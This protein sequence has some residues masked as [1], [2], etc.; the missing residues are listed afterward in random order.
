MLSQTASFGQQYMVKL[1]PLSS[2]ASESREH[3]RYCN[4]RRLWKTKDLSSRTNFAICRLVAM[5]WKPRYGVFMD[6]SYKLTYPDGE[7]KWLHHRE[8]AAGIM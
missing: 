7:S 3:S 6:E 4:C 8:K 1:P 2:N 5:E